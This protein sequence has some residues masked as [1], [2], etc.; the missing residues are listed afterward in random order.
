MD[1][2][3]VPKIGALSKYI[4]EPSEAIY[5]FPNRECLEDALVNWMGDIYEHLEEEEGESIRLALLEVDLPEDWPV[6]IPEGK[7]F[8]DFYEVVTYERIPA[9]FLKVIKTDL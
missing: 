2:G 8:R 5:L 4:D 7:K 9:K 1:I 6:Y 3:L